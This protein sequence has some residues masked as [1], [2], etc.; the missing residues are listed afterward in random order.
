MSSI[1]N[2][3]SKIQN[4]K[5]I[6]PALGEYGT[7]LLKILSLSHL[8]KSNNRLSFNYIYPRRLYFL[9]SALLGHFLLL[10]LNS[11]EFIVDKPIFPHNLSGC[12][13]VDDHLPD[14][15]PRSVKFSAR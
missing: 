15:E 13:G 14:I 4:P 12:D 7:P 3:K 1:Q 9:N 2:P 6:D 5:L 8:K 10:S 11:S